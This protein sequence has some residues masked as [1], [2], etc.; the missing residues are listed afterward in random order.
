MKDGVTVVVDGSH[1]DTL[2]LTLFYRFMPEL[3]NAGHV[4][5]ATPPLY[6]VVPAKGKEEYLYN[7]AALAK[8]RKAHPS[9]K[10]TLQRYKGCCQSLPLSTFPL[11]RGVLIKFL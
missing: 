6:K 10:F 7:D 1:I 9:G 4:Y 11:T 3:I 5:L 8:Y 2:L